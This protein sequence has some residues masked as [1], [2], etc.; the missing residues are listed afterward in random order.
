[1]NNN[2][3]SSALNI[4]TVY[5]TNTVDYPGMYV[6]RLFEGDKPTD[7]FY[8]HEDLEAVRTWILDEAKSLGDHFHLYRMKRA[9]TDDP[10]ILETWI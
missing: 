6:A 1:M 5:G 7:N 3:S 2:K 10:V 4:W 9:P 8:V